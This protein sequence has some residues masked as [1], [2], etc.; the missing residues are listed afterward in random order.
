[1][2]L[3]QE[4]RPGSPG[5]CTMHAQHRELDEVRGRA[6]DR[7]VDGGA[8]R[9]RALGAVA[10]P[11]LRQVAA[12]AEQR[13]DPAARARLLDGRV[14]VAPHAGVHREIAVDELLCLLELQP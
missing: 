2:D 3:E 5:E 4:T 10:A 14:E 6:L 9:E 1:M 11:E 8:L 7:R 12:A 13:R